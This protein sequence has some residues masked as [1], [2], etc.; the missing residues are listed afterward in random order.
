MDGASPHIR[1]LELDPRSL[2]TQFAQRRLGATLHACR[3][4]R[5]EYATPFS[6]AFLQLERTRRTVARWEGALPSDLL[7]GLEACRRQ[8]EEASHLLNGLSAVSDARQGE[9]ALVDLAALV[10]SSLAAARSELER[11]G[12]ETRVEAPAETIWVRGFADELGDAVR[13]ALLAVSRRAASGHARIEIGT[14]SGTATVSFQV[15]LASEAPGEDLFRARGRNGADFG[16]FLARWAF[17]SHGGSVVCEAV[18]RT[19]TLTGT[20]PL[21]AA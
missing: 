11:L 6:A 9:P 20:L 12:L 10:A 18:G 17:E 19:L 8:L 16:P 15:P 21:A 14:P 3:A 1:A 13:E 7:D 2:D 5:H 4:L